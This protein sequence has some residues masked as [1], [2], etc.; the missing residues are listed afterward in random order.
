MINAIL[1]KQAPLDGSDVCPIRGPEA[2]RNGSDASGLS[3]ENRAPE[4]NV[5]DSDVGSFPEAGRRRLKA[6]ILT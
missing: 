4:S 5:S 6:A 2:R 1:L 3:E